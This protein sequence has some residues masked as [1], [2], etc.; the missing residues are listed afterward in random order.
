MLPLWQENPNAHNSPSD[1][2]RNPRKETN[3]FGLNILL[4]HEFRRRHHPKGLKKAEGKRN[5]IRC[6]CRYG[7]EKGKN[8]K[9]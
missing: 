9:P 2:I 7:R 3:P 4:R 1:P 6:E 5:N 8:H